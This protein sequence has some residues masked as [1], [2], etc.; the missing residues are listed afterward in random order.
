M[1]LGRLKEKALKTI[2]E[3]GV[4]ELG[5]KT[6][7]FVRKKIGE[8]QQRNM[9][10]DCY[11]DVLFI[12][13]CGTVLPHPGRYRV[14]HQREQLMSQGLT[15]D[16]I[17]YQELDIRQTRQY[18]VFIFFRCPCTPEIEA[19]IKTARLYQKTVLYDIDDLVFDTIYT[20]TIPYVYRMK[21]EDRQAYDANV[22]SMGKL[23][24][25]CQ[26]A[27]TTTGT[28]EKELKKHVQHVL[29]NRNTASEELA[30]LSENARQKKQHNQKENIVTLGYFSGSITHNP[31]IEMLLPVLEK[32]LDKY[33]NVEILIAGELDIPEKLKKYQNRIK[34]FGFSDW[35]KLP[36]M[37]AYTDIN[38][39][40]LTDSIFNAAKSENKWMEA[41]LVEVATV[42]SDIGAFRESI[43]H[44]KTGYLCK[45]QEDWYFYLSELIEKEELRKEIAHNAWNV[46]REKYL[47]T[48]TG[49]LLANFIKNQRHKNA[50]FLFPA[51]NISG[52]IMVAMRHAVILKENGYDVTFITDHMQD[53][54]YSF[55]NQKFPVLPLQREKIQGYFDKMIATMWVTAD[56][57]RNYW[58]V[59]EKF[60]LVQNY[61]TDFY[62][63]GSPYRVQANATYGIGQ[64]IF[65][66][67][68]SRW[69]QNWLQEK[70]QVNAKYAPNGIETEKFSFSERNYDT[71]KIRILIEGDCGVEHKNVDESFAIVEKLD[72]RKYEIWYLSYESQP[73]KWYHVDKFFHKILYNK[74][75]SI[76]KQ[77][78]ILLKS[79]TLESFSYP[80]LE[81]MATGGIAVVREN[82]GNREY[83]VNEENCLIY[84]PE[85]LQS[86]VDCIERIEYDEALRKRLVS[87]G[88]RTAEEREWNLIE[89]DILRLYE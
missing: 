72:L 34:S 24:D 15:S 9:D 57:L 84:N 43:I 85:N 52:G 25:M 26:G 11:K 69:C 22:R 56:F 21:Q 18:G 67:T 87:G 45:N 19:F 86:A 62:E 3:E 14:S 80:P 73:K 10:F 32:L 74:V 12:D 66:I 53:N 1:E 28:L 29:V 50:A 49:T 89:N 61:E 65:Y 82:G 88:K 44:G 30:L 38:L 8:K 51:L 2:R 16:A 70:F 4:L 81:M 77:C 6:S 55:E 36:E 59:K 47:T 58:N 78:H 37:I 27:I 68:I 13:G 35:R 75:S 76:Y 23:L 42:A 48:Y 39:A 83:L 41:A 20:D 54:S 40:P 17:Y 5:K 60:Y 31:D 63:L 7:Q 33:S 79:S 46:C 71:G 64:D